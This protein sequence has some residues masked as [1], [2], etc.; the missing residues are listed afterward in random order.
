MANIIS[1]LQMNQND[2]VAFALISKGDISA[3]VPSVGG[4]GFL[5]LLK[6]FKN[7]GVQD[8]L[9]RSNIVKVPLEFIN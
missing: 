7:N 1:K 8:S 3:G 5:E 4:K 6:E 2:L 9:E